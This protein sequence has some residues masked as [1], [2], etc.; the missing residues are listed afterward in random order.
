MHWQFHEC[1]CTR[2]QASAR[3]SGLLAPERGDTV[4]K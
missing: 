2:R 4:E 3:T 1:D